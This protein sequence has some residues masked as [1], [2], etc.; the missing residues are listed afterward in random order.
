MM[1]RIVIIFICVLA[2]MHWANAGTLTY[3]RANQLYHNQQYTEAL[4]LYNQM[5]NEG[6]VNASVYY[7]AGNTYYKLKKMGWAVWCY[8]KALQLEPNNISSKENL[9]LAQKKIAS[10]LFVASNSPID[11]LQL[12]VNFHSQNTWA[13]GALLFFTLA[14]LLIILK[15]RIVIPPFFIAIRKMCWLLFTIYF[16]G[17]IGHY[18]FHKICKY[19][20]ILENTI[21]Y[22]NPKEKGLQKE[23]STEGIKVQI[24]QAI[25]GSVLN[26]GKYKVQLP[27]GRIAW[28]EQQFV[29]KL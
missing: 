9:L 8:Q 22:N 29:G 25:K 1:H 21:L 6:M 24:L 14:M 16:I 5:I 19:G 12:G 13:L 28:V 10:P 2:S 4:E 3:E 7:N 15:K 11:W 18:L 17:T 23:E 27:N 26:A 20:V